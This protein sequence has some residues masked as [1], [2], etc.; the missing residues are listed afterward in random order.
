MALGFYQSG[1][2]LLKSVIKKAQ[3]LE[4]WETVLTGSNILIGY[5]S[6]RGDNH[7]SD[8]YTSLS[9]HAL[10][11]VSK[12]LEL[13][14][15]YNKWMLIFSKKRSTTN[16]QIQE[17]GK[18]VL[19]GKKIV[20]ELKSI[21]LV[22]R[23]RM[24]ELIYLDAKMDHSK[25]LSLSIETARFIRENSGYTD[26]NKLAFYVGIQMYAY[27]NLK[28]LEDAKG[29]MSDFEKMNRPGTLNWFIFLEYYFVLLIQ[30]GK[31]NEAYEVY[32]KIVNNSGYNLLK[33]V[34]KDVWTLLTA[35]MQ[36]LAVSALWKDAPKEIATMDFKSN[37]FIN[38]VFSL[39]NDKTGLNVSI[40]ILQVLFLLHYGRYEDIF[41]KKDAL[42]RYIYRYLYSKENERS[43]T[44]MTMLLR[45]IDQEFSFAKTIEKTKRLQTQL[46]SLNMNY[47]AN[48][49]GNEIVDYEI[50][51]DWVLN[52]LKTKWPKAA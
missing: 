15:M 25:L 29:L 28:R 44:F 22:N 7:N 45:M 14:R 31:P 37:K 43:R 23:A 34:Q 2:W 21:N 19:K 48:L 51:W 3:I 46:A 16:D 24:L 52:T 42:R 47:R 4:S 5:Y 11:L 26:V 10:G 13:K 40:L 49:G 30:S 50:L 17:L 38:D 33:G 1:L 9:Q 20:G 35:Y 36:F 6:V 32:I 8:L 18:D 12:E 39:G 27:L 41:D